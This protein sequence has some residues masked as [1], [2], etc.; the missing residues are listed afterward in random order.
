MGRQTFT[1]AL[2]YGLLPDHKLLD[3]G[4]GCLRLGYWF[5][6]FL[7]AGCYHAS[8]RAN[9]KLSWVGSIYFRRTYGSTS[10]P[11]SS[12][13]QIP[14]MAEFGVKFDFVVARSILTH[15]AP[16]M[17]SKI[18][19]EFAAN[20]ASGACLLASYLAENKANHPNLRFGDDVSRDSVEWARFDHSLPY[21]RE[22]AA[23][24]GL[25]VEEY[26]VARLLNNQRWVVCR[27]ILE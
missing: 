9:R 13:A 3:F 20:G 26:P 16:G 10:G 14:A 5:I 4:A 12:I 15:A 1:V 8:N 6:L 17:L 23:E 25:S 24:H 19:T 7:D 2:N 21:L 27:R 18:F 11:R 22:R